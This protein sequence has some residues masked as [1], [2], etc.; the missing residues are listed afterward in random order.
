VI[1]AL[2]RLSRDPHDQARLREQ[3][4]H[5][6]WCWPE[7]D[8]TR[9]IA[10]VRELDASEPRM[11]TGHVPLVTVC[12][13]TVSLWSLRIGDPRSDLIDSAVPLGPVA[14]AAWRAA[15]LALPRSLP[16]LCRSV[17]DM[18]RSRRL[19]NRVASWTA[20]GI[21]AAERA[22]DG[23]SCGL[24]FA[25]ALASIAL[26]RS[27]PPD[28]VAS[29]AVD[30]SGRLHSVEHLRLK[31]EGVCELAPRVRRFVVAAS[32]RDD[33]ERGARGRLEVLGAS[34]VAQAL[35]LLLGGDLAGALLDSA[36]DAEGR[37]EVVRSFFRL[38]FAGRDAA[39]DWTPV[40]QGA[41]LA[42]ERWSAQLDDEARFL[43]AFTAAI[44]ARHQDN[45]A[46]LHGSRAHM[47]EPS[48][49]WFRRQPM[50]VR[51]GIAAHL[52]QH[53]ADTGTPDA[54]AAERWAAPFLPAHLNDAYP[55]QLRLAG[56]MARLR[57]VTGRPRE[58][59]QVQEQL[60]AALFQNF[61]HQATSFQVS[62]WYRLA[63]ACGDAD[64]LERARRFD[65]S[66]ELLGGY[67]GE[68]RYYV[69]LARAKGMLLLGRSVDYEALG[70]LQ[71]LCEGRAP[72]HVRHSARR[73]LVRALEAA[74]R[75]V[76]RHHREALAAA[77]R[78]GMSADARKQLALVRL[79]DALRARD[80][81]VAEAALA[82]L[83]E[84]DPG[85][86]GLLETAADGT[87]AEYV[88][89]YYPY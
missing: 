51:V 33:A 17:A 31:I 75:E 47:P 85:P 80:G 49:D 58:A 18:A 14:D 45:A 72:D 88:A 67:A 1:T 82:S 10:Y 78:E 76:G 74:D 86:V 65:V 52:A 30:A 22:I 35:E 43:L 87:R 13:T 38:A 28:F 2:E 53:A 29:A 27:L 69:R 40:E 54:A 15:Q 39:I 19:V 64:A 57:A 77:A 16:V 68:G 37:T 9:R 36:R 12:G 60:A 61:E 41:R 70:Q 8:D 59:L 48:T 63:G 83:R 32:Q 66:V 50:S 11:D 25:L 4:D 62:E 46:T 42:A 89:R 81:G 55:S 21:A 5:G 6:P 73:W 20:E 71:R 7:E 23:P 24:P 79:D 84:E 3:L 26:G 56:A 44:A 34:S